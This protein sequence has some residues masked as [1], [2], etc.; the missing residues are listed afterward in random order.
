MPEDENSKPEEAVEPRPETETEPGSEPEPIAEPEA[1]SEEPPADQA[2]TPPEAE[3]D[4]GAAPS[5]APGTIVR[6]TVLVVSDEELRLQL[7]GGVEG[8][9]ARQD[10]HSVDGTTPPTEGSELDVYVLPGEGRGQALR[11]SRKLALGARSAD[12]LERCFAE[13]LP[14]EGKISARKKGGYEVFISGMRAFLPASHVDLH[15]PQDPDSYVGMI[16]RFKILEMGKRRGNVVVS[17][18]KVLEEEARIRQQELIGAI[19]PGQVHDGKVARVKE[20]GAFVDIGGLEGLV[21]T[22]EF[23]WERVED[24]MTFLTP[25]QEVKVK[26][27]RYGQQSGKLS[28]SIRMVEGNPWD[29]LGEEFVEGEVYP[30]TVT[31]FEAF[32]AFVCLAPGLDGLVH[33]TE[34]SW[35]PG[36]RHA[37][38]VLVEGQEI[39]VKL[40]GFDKKRRRVSLSHKQIEP[41]P[42]AAAVESWPVGTKARGTIE[43]IAKFGVFVTLA[44]GITALI[45]V[46]RTGVPKDRS[47]HRKFKVGAEIEADVIEVDPRRRRVTLSLAEP[48]GGEDR[49]VS[50][51]L[52]EQKKEKVSFGKLGDLLSDFDPD[53]D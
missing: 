38:Q 46:S 5:I 40:L 36:V 35:D 51:F 39:Q 33:N 24:P 41:D 25:G 16:S 8:I 29:R 44:P 50:A 19:E 28:L 34:V 6:G 4:D 10:F 37:D 49:D 22:S 27:L 7:P 20:F 13:S 47:L 14:I 11:L 15:Q 52:K 1:T 23:S 32:G 2:E 53:E 17:R 48:E 9:V 26:V 31:H 30:G 42:W 18:R 21:H 45:P 12:D 3:A 43:N